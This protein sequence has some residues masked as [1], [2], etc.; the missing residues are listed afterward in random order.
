MGFYLQFYSTENSWFKKDLNLQ[1]HLHQHFFS[2]NRFLDS[3]HKYFFDQ[4][5]LKLRKEKWSFLNQ[6]FT[7]YV[8]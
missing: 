5:T 7:V 2:D 6:E 8:F 1:I 3:F 4:T